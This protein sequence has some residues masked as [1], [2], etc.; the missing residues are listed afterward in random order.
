MVIN[1]VSSAG[2]GTH[3]VACYVSKNQVEYVHSFGLELSTMVVRP[4][5]PKKSFSLRD[6][7]HERDYIEIER[8]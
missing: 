3:W 8:P 2:G 1:L 6:T 7:I 4:S 5:G